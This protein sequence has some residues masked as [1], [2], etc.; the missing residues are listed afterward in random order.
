[1]EHKSVHFKSATWMCILLG[2]LMASNGCTQSQ[3]PISHSP[4][5]ARHQTFEHQAGDS[6]QSD[7][8]VFHGARFSSNTSQNQNSS[9]L[10]HSTWYETRKDNRPGVLAGYQGPIIEQV[11][12]RTNDRQ[13]FHNG[14]AH[15]SYQRN[16][17]RRRFQQITR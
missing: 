17:Y 10:N 1:M 14:D 16:S 13:H 3:Q 2:L 4:W 9:V 8:L 12:T 7:T 11:Y 6:K 15:N 5:L